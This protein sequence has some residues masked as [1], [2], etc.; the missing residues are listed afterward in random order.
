MKTNNRMRAV[1]RMAWRFVREAGIP[2]GEAMHRANLNLRF[3]AKIAKGQVHFYYVKANGKM[4][5]AWGVAAKA[6]QDLVKGTGCKQPARNCLYFDT[7]KME[8]RC[9]ARARLVALA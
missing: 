9:F 2:L 1:M 3:N 7:E 8:F 6:G 4:R 5:E